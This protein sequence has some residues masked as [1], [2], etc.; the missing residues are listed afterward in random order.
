MVWNKESIAEYLFYLLIFLLPWQTRY[1]FHDPT[2]FGGIWEYG[3][4]SIYAWDILL[5]IIVVGLWPKLRQEFAVAFRHSRGFYAYLLF[6]S[7]AFMTGGWAAEPLL[8]SYWGWRLLEGGF[9]WLLVRVLKPDIK[10]IF[11]A[12]MLAGSLQ[13]VWGFGQFATQSTFANKWLGVAEHPVEMGGTSVLLNAGGRWLRAYGG[14]VH[15]NVLGGL[16]VITC[17]A[18]VWLFMASL[19]KMQS[20]QFQ[21][22]ERSKAYALLLLF[23]LQLIGLF[24]TF[25]RA[26]WLAL[27]GALFAAGLVWR[28]QRKIILQ[29]GVITVL[30]FIIFSAGLWQPTKARLMGSSASRLERQAIDERVR[31]YQASKS[32]LT[33]VWWRGVGLGNYTKALADY[34]PGLRAYRYQP[35]HNIFILVLSELGIIGLALWLAFLW[36]KLRHYPR[37]LLFFPFVFLFTSLFDHYWWTSASMFLLFWLI[38]ALSEV[39]YAPGRQGQ[40]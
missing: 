19:S 32:L 16:L 12:L 40:T 28:T 34:Q 3:R 5:L 11:I 2:L 33:T 37:E 29:I 36:Q 10:Q 38:L 1:I 20:P 21:I 23:T 8:V 18:T 15:P 22:R 14:Q 35:V 39:Y 31:G 17:L 6:T 25:S 30:I 9:M 27:F 13:A 26:N 4:L 24:V 7:F